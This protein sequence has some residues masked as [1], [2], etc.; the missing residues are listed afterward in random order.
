MT[1]VDKKS[2]AYIAREMAKLYKA[3][4]PRSIKT[5]RSGSRVDHFTQQI[6]FSP[7]YVTS[8]GVKWIRAAE[9]LVAPCERESVSA[10]DLALAFE[11]THDPST[12]MPCVRDFGTWNWSSGPVFS[13]NLS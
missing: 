12:D 6:E 10:D 4:G 7:V 8:D 9:A 2:V 1:E 13:N 5:L 11:A 3:I